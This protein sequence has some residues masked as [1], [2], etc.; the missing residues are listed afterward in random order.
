MFKKNGHKK[1]TLNIIFN[2]SK[3]QTKRDKYKDSE[4]PVPFQ[5]S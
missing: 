4:S 5:A 2:K 1:Q 3:K